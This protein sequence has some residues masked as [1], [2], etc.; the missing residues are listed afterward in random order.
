MRGLPGR[1]ATVYDRC[2]RPDEWARP[3]VRPMIVGPVFHFELVRIARRWYLYAIRFGFG[4][5]L[6]AILCLNFLQ[7]LDFEHPWLILGAPA[8]TLSQLAR[9]GQS[10]FYSLIWAQGALVATL[11]PGL[12]ADAIAGERQRKTLHYLMNTQLWAGEI[13]LGKLVARMLHLG[14]FIAVALPVLSL[15]SLIGGIDPVLL[16]WSSLA[17]VSTGYVLATLSILASATTRRPRDAF[18]ASYTYGALF[19]V[20]PYFVTGLSA[21]RT[22]WWTPILDAVVA[23]ND[24]VWPASPL[25]LL[26][27]SNLFA[28]FGLGNNTIVDQLA[29]MIAFQAAYGTAFLVLTCLVLRPAYRWIESRGASGSFWNRRKRVRLLPRPPVG[30]EPVYWK[31]AHVAATSPGPLR[32]LVRT[33]LLIL[34]CGITATI[35]TWAP[36]AFRELRDQGFFATDYSVYKDRSNFNW[37]LRIG[38]G[39]LMFL[40]LIALGSTTAAAIAVEREQDTWLSL[41]ATPMEGPEVLRGKMLGPLR[42]MAPV[43]AP[44]L[45]LWLVGLAAGSVHP[46][47]LVLAVVAFALFTWFVTAL[48]TFCSLQARTAWRAQGIVLAVL[49]LPYFCCYAF[50]SPVTLTAGALLSYVDVTGLLT[51]KLPEFH[52]YNWVFPMMVVM[53]VVVSPILYAVGA[54]AFTQVTFATFDG[55]ALRPRAPI[56]VIEPERAFLAATKPLAPDHGPL[57]S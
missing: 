30:D 15:L 8:V 56:A 54:W 28:L 27:R 29:G 2:P 19:F 16:L 5:L 51:I 10:L 14:V 39:A 38:T 52:N 46:L 44:I 53:Y 40:W 6:L 57:G 41:L 18:V 23:A 49:V 48:S 12:V 26:S 9:F 45:V 32:V 47:G 50:P 34:I 17:L 35:L 13:V 43:G 37:A 55:M 3:E 21:V 42:A 4:A 36:D 33:C 25:G 22:G 20:L 1:F 7:F 31:E 11:T 24:W